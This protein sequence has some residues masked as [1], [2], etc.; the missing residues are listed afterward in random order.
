MTAYPRLKALQS[1][2]ELRAFLDDLNEHGVHDRVA[3]MDDAGDPFL[4]FLAGPY[5][6]TAAAYAYNPRDPEIN[7]P[8]H[9]DRCDECG[10]VDPLKL[11]DLAYPVVVLV[12]LP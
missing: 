11:A 6:E 7:P 3:G 1:A 4:A 12:G 10:G 5:A 2:D 8:Q 9:T